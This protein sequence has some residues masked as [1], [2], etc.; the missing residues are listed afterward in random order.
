M[1]RLSIIYHSQSGAAESLA[2]AAYL[3][4][5]QEDSVEVVLIR[6]MEADSVQLSSSDGVLFVTPENFG[7]MSGGLKDYFVR[8]YYVL[9]EQQLNIPYALAVSA[10]NDGTGAVREVERIAQGYPLKKV[11]EPVIV[12]GLPDDAG[13]EACK[14]LGQTMAVGMAFG[15]Y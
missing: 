6:A 15:I 4:A 11:A 12:R 7:G 9:L 13:L 14:E 2:K 10:G 8:T 5:K 1:K 3:G